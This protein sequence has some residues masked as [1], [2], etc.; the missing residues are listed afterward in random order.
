M[1]QEEEEKSFV[2]KEGREMEGTILEAFVAPC[3][4]HVGI[5]LDLSR[6]L[7]SYIKMAQIE[8]P[9]FLYKI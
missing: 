3:V 4:C 1:F 5:P 9:K 7:Q 6:V 2:K 8:D